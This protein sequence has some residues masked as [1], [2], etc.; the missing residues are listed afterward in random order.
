MVCSG[1]TLCPSW[2]LVSTN[3]VQSV[4]MAIA[5]SSC[6]NSLKACSSSAARRAETI[7][8]STSTDALRAV[9]SVRSRVSSPL[10]PSSWRTRRPLK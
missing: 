7:P 10:S 4:A 6:T 3:M 2:A 9:I 8:S 5:C 1:V